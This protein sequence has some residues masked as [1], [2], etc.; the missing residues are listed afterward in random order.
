[1][2]VMCAWHMEPGNSSEQPAWG[3]LRSRKE[4]EMSFGPMQL[5]VIGFGSNDR[6]SGE[7]I[8]ELDWVRDT[9]QIRLIDALFV[10]RSDAGELL[11]VAESDLTIDESLEFGAVVGALL[12]FGMAG[13]DGA[14]AGAVAGALSIA[15]NNYGVGIDML[16]TLASDIPP[17]TSALLLLIEHT[18]AIGLRDAV[19]NAGG[20]VLSQAMLTPEALMLAGAELGA[21]LDESE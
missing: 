8:E 15:E 2:T 10:A 16:E 12:G 9:R 20:I 18:W 7:I 19:R 4:D 5:V 13:D 6:F 17:G 1:M 11:A 14:E 21:L 3:G